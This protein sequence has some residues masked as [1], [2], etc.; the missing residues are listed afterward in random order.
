MATGE[1]I[2]TNDI[3]SHTLKLLE[4]SRIRE[5]VASFCLSDE[6]RELL[7]KQKFLADRKKNSN[8]L[9]QSVEYR[10]ILEAGS[11]FPDLQFPPVSIHF[12]ILEKE[13]T[14][15]EGRHLADI[16]VFLISSDK[17]KKFLSKRISE[18]AVSTAREI[19]Y[20]SRLKASVELIPDTRELASSI[21]SKLEKDGSVKESV[22]QL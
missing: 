3:F 4:F 16:G 22:P 10:T 15:L 14:V 7:A 18:G 5:E 13:G 6:G 8:F 11:I 21:F 19:R 20:E 2:E 12:P 9:D 17:L 1:S